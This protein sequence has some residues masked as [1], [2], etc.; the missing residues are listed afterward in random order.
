MPE[1]PKR[2]P[3]KLT[4]QPQRQDGTNAWNVYNHPTQ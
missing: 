2:E 3:A 4:Q 1:N